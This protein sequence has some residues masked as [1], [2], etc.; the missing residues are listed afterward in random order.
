MIDANLYRIR[1]GCY[2]HQSGR[3]KFLNKIDYYKQFTRRENQAGKN[4][5]QIIKTF[6]KIAAIL[7]LVSGVLC[8][9]THELA[10]VRTCSVGEQSGSGQSDL[11]TQ[12]VFATVQ[13]CQAGGLV[14][15][16]SGLSLI[17]LPPQLVFATVQSFQAG[18]NIRCVHSGPGLID[19]SPQL[20]FAT[21]LY[22]SIFSNNYQQ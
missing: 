19:L 1:I 16:H 8:S 20:V 22:Y 10:G 2:N 15:G 14:R 12:L 17:D 11:F 9:T 7:C 21:I 13:T 5:L 3:K 4:V 6:C 18:G